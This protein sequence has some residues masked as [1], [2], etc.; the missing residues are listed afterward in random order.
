MRQRTSGAVFF[1]RRMAGMI[2][3]AV[4]IAAETFTVF[5]DSFPS[6]GPKGFVPKDQG[7]VGGIYYKNNMALIYQY[8]ID[9]FRNVRLDEAK[10]ISQETGKGKPSP[11]QPFKSMTFQQHLDW[12]YP[13]MESVPAAFSDEALLSDAQRFSL[14]ARF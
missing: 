2:L 10:K 8:R 1:A 12:K 14:T 3:A 6:A 5:G 9:F 4:L 13:P 11:V 7:S